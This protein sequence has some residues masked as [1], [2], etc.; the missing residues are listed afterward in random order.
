MFHEFLLL[1]IVNVFI[2]ALGVSLGRSVLFVRMRREENRKRELELRLLQKRTEVVNEGRQITDNL[3]ELLY[4]AQ[5]Q[6]EINEMIRKKDS[7]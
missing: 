6:Q 1:T 2:L 7:Q 4:Q 5:V 3:E